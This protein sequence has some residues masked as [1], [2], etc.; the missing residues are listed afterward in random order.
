MADPLNID[1]YTRLQTRYGR[2]LI[3]NEGEAAYPHITYSGGRQRIVLDPEGEMYRICCPACERQ[4]TRDTRF[5]LY[6]NHLWGVGHA[7][8]PNDDFWWAAHCFNESCMSNP[9][10]RKLLR[11][12]VYNNIGRDIRRGAQILPGDKADD[13]LQPKQLPGECCPLTELPNNHPAKEF[14]RIRGYDPD[15]IGHMYDLHYCLHVPPMIRKLSIVQ[16][17]IIAPFKMDG[18]LVGWQARFVG[19]ATVQKT[20]KYFTC[21]GMRTGRVLYDF[22]R[23][24]L[25]RVVFICEGITD[26]WSVGSGAVALCGKNFSNRHFEYVCNTWPVAVVLL[27]PDAA[28]ESGDIYNKLSRRITVIRVELPQQTDPAS[29]ARDFLFE[30]IY[31]AGHAVGIDLADTVKG[32][33]GNAI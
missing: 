8:Y 24:R 10:N 32:M 30:K 21:P 23:A 11:D 9:A 1:L 3:A 25:S 2:V 14:M 16:G 13:P 28:R 27:D 22:D 5:R 12:E 7:G 20:V 15:V 18:Q 29:L 4:G 19:N 33:V 6:I 26:V 31:M 17:R